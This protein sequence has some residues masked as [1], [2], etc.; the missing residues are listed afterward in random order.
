MAN[1]FLPDIHSNVEPFNFNVEVRDVSCAAARRRWRAWW[2]RCHD[3]C[4]VVGGMRSLIGKRG[5]GNTS[6]RRTTATL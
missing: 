6:T 1:T 2:L 5:T 4:G 3:S